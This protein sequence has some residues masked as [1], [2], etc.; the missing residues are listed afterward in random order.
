MP[1]PTDW[2]WPSQVQPVTPSGMFSFSF[3]QYSIAAMPFSSLPVNLPSG[4]KIE[5]PWLHSQAVQSHSRL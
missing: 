4:P 2:P 1:W 5:P 3:C